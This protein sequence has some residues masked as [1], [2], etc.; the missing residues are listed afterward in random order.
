M[1]NNDNA[2]NDN[3]QKEVLAVRLLSYSTFI[4]KL[5]LFLVKNEYLFCQNLMIINLD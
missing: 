4:S 1:F 2:W 3:L 5:Q